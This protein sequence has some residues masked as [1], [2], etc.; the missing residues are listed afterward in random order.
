MPIMI[1]KKIENYMSFFKKSAN[2]L[3]LI[4][5][6]FSKN[7][8][9]HQFLIS[10][11]IKISQCPWEEKINEFLKFAKENETAFNFIHG[12]YISSEK[13]NNLHFHEEIE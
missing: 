2:W 5:E 11:E 4:R 13:Y 6:N 1:G 12:F 8:V 7:C 3:C 10:L 9:V